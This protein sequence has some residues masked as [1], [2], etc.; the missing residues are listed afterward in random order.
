MK[1]IHV[2]QYGGPE[3]LEVVGVPEPVPGSRQVLVKM[4]VTG[5]NFHDAATRK[6]IFPDPPLKL[7]FIPGVEG[8]GI[9]EAVGSEVTEVKVGDRVSFNV[10]G[11][12][13]Y[14]EKV[15]IN[16]DRAIPL[17]DDISFEVAASMTAQGMTAHYLMN[18]FCPV[19]PG[20][21]VLIQAAASGMGILLTQWAK[22]LGATVYATVSNAS[23]A[24]FVKKLGADEVILYTQT[25]LV[26]AVKDLTDG[27]GVDFVIDGVGTTIQQSLEAVKTR[28]LVITYGMNGGVPELMNPFNL[29]YRSRTLAGADLFDFIESREDLLKRAYA[30]FDGYREGWLKQ[31]IAHM[32]PLEEAQKAHY[33]MQ[34][35]N[36]IGKILLTHDA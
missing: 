14:A 24:Q 8:A 10:E 29:L 1:A 35:R 22:H 20:T 31:S 18:E 4:K 30:A 16:A 12:Q 15:V 7:P 11:A 17:P 19:E 6:G 5:Y 2:T 21:T 25:D 36:L 32:L 34:D 23:K 3:V 9:V 26:K 28:G 13:S 33:L 27:K